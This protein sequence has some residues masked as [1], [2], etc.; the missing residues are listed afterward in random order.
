[1]FSSTNRQ[2]VE[3][4]VHHTFPENKL[5]SAD[6]LLSDQQSK[7]RYSVYK[8]NINL[9]KAANSHVEEAATRE[10][11]LFLQLVFEKQLN[12]LIGYKKKLLII[13]LLIH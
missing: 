13:V 8:N 4:N 12:R 9:R 10:R 7:K 3:K 1:M 2:K 5:T 11:A 6:V